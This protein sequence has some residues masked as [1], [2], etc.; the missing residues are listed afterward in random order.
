M[1]RLLLAI[2][3]L[4]AQDTGLQ[5]KIIEGEG[6]AY[7]ARSR[8]TRGIAVQVVDA[9]GT[10]VEGASVTFQLPADGPSGV[11]ASGGRMELAATGVDGRASVWGMQWNRVTGPLELRITAAKD[12]MRASI[13]CPLNLTEAAPKEARSHRKLWII[14]G[15]A[16]GVAGAAATLGGSSSQGGNGAAAVVNTPTIGAPAVVISHP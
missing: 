5:I 9:R 13:V 11:F 6:V 7:A 14:L 3:P 4:A 15:I 16:G 10:A 1:L 12:Q 2:L 8:A